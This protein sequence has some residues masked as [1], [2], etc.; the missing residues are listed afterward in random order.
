[1]TIKK[2]IFRRKKKIKRAELTPNEKRFKSYVLTAKERK[3]I[4]DELKKL[5]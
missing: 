1:M 4:D 5:K 2:M 3:L